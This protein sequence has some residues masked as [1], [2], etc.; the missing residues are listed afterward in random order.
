MFKREASP[1][2]SNFPCMDRNY[3]LQGGTN[4]RFP[5]DEVPC[6]LCMHV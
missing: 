3:I 5:A 4:N 1:R 6:Y 2:S